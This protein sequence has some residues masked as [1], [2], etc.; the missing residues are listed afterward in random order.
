MRERQPRILSSRATLAYKIGLLGPCV[1]WLLYLPIVLR[2]LPPE[3]KWVSLVFTATGLAVFIGVYLLV[4]RARRVEWVGNTLIVSSMN[5][6]LEIP[7][8]DVVN[9]NGIPFSRPECLWLDLRRPS[10]LGS[11]IYFLPPQRWFKLFSRHPIEAELRSIVEAQTV[12]DEASRRTTRQRSTRDKVAIG[13]AVF[14]AFCGVMTAVIVSAFT[15]MMKSGEPYQH[16]L[17]MVQNSELAREQLG[18]PIVPGWLVM[19]SMKSV[20]QQAAAKL[21]FAVSGTHEAGTVRLA[22]SREAGPWQFSVLELD[23]GERSF[24]LL[25]E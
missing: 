16:A 23:T 2:M 9:V 10:E 18:A 22:A 8:H 14:T 15:S 4:G 5:K 20:D 1:A 25:D 13:L 11:R 7:I 24:N 3:A 6:T 12:P 19:G 21:S 17:S